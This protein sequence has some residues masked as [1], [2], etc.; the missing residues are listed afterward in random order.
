MIPFQV[1]NIFL[2]ELGVN[3]MAGTGDNFA[4][5]FEYDISSAETERGTQLSSGEVA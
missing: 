2:L 4:G 5:N 1:Q 3:K